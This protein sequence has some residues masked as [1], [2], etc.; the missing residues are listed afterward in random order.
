[1]NETSPVAAWSPDYPDKRDKRVGLSDL[2]LQTFI[3][4]KRPG[5]SVVDYPLESPAC[6]WIDSKHVYLRV[7]WSQWCTVSLS[8]PDHVAA[9]CS[10]HYCRITHSANNELSDVTAPVY[11]IAELPREV[12]VPESEKE[13]PESEEVSESMAVPGE[14]AE[15]LDKVVKIVNANFPQ[16]SVYHDVQFDGDHAA[17]AV[18]ND[19]LAVLMDVLPED[20]DFIFAPDTGKN[21]HNPMNRWTSNVVSL[22]FVSKLERLQAWLKGAEPDCEVKIGLVANKN[23]LDEFL[24]FADKVDLAEFNLFTYENLADGL[25]ELFKEYFDEDNSNT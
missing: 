6:F 1:M 22:D 23:T 4:D 7:N 25:G 12:V 5:I 10:S 8:S 11:H 13:G 16:L 21:R 24:A 17:I 3:S 2:E 9:I 18:S 19:S 14:Y 20:R 15:C